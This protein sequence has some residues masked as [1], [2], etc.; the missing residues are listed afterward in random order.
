MER[1][2]NEI[3]TET[4]RLAQAIRQEF[5]QC[6]EDLSDIQT[7]V[8]LND[9]GTVENVRDVIEQA[10]RATRAANL[11]QALDVI[12]NADP[13]AVAELGDTALMEAQLAKIAQVQ[14][15][16]MEREKT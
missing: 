1:D 14:V 3:E 6:P 15:M 7:I 9:N 8:W 2:M 4:R 12:L 13:H 11:R 10:V 5:P 16:L